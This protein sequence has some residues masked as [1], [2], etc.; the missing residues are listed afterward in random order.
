MNRTCLLAALVAMTPLWGCGDAR[1]ECVAASSISRNGFA[2]DP[3]AVRRLEGQTVRLCGFVDHGNVGVESGAGGSGEHSAGA[4]VPHAEVW[5]FHLKAG[6]GDAVGQSFAVRVPA[7]GRAAE[8]E[9]AFR[10]DARRGRA[11]AVH[12]SGRIETF[13]APTNVRHLVGLRLQVRSS[14]DVRLD[15]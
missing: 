3:D 4:G 12:V 10:E 1:R 13:D 8:L 7:D 14:A 2:I 5:V 11:T 9:A 6:P 15:R